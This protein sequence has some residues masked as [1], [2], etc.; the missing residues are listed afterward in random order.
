MTSFI[1]EILNSNYSHFVYFTDHLKGEITQRH[2][3]RAALGKSKAFQI[4]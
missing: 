1:F 3:Q 4:Q 2:I